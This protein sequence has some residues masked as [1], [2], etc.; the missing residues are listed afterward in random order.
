MS[1]ARSSLTLLACSLA[2]CTL[3]D[4]PV[5]PA[6]V[7]DRLELLNDAAAFD[8]RVTYTG[9][10]T[11][12]LA[13]DTG[14]ALR[15]LA[16]ATP[17]SRASFLRSAVI[18]APKMNGVT[19]LASHVVVHGSH[20]YVS[21]MTHGEVANGAV[22]SFDVSQ[23]GRPRLISQLLL[24][25]TDVLS[26]ATD[27]ND[28]YLATSS[29]DTTYR[30]RAV[31]ERIKVQGGRLTTQSTRVQVPSYVATGVDLSSKYVFVTSGSGGPGT[32]GLTLLDRKTLARVSGDVFTD[33]RAVTGAGGKFA[34]VSQGGP[35]RLRLYDPSSGA[36]LRTVTLQGGTIPE[37]KSA[38]LLTDT[39][40]FVA[41]GDGGVQVVDLAAGV[42][43]AVVPRPNVA[44]VATQDQ[45]TNAVTVVQDFILAADGGAGVAV[46]WSDHRSAR[47]GSRP[48]IL[49]LGRLLL[50]GSANFVASDHDALFVAQGA[51]GF[52]VLSLR[53]S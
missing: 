45:V 4:A 6:P 20:A 35:G 19:L 27:G 38:V 22:E 30:E 14:V 16:S 10:D 44:G 13:P 2:A 31:L 46:S 9:N 34:A 42:V 28:V 12:P 7:E 3:G 15:T 49:P 41:T 48:A 18:S 40:G 39:W 50:P 8:D 25:G 24:K 23:P 29:D 36:L 52:Q 17:P 47:S 32:G 21:Y 33:A 26:L 1:I 5:A 53:T 11:V 51:A 43:R 37:S